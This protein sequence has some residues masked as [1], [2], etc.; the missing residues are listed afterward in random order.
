MS[1]LQTENKV[2]AF[3]IIALVQTSLNVFLYLLDPSIPPVSSVSAFATGVARLSKG[4]DSG[5]TQSSGDIASPASCNRT[6][7][8]QLVDAKIFD[9]GL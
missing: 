8:S 7:P 3:E 5:V 9:C 1:S 2:A 4:P 6:Q